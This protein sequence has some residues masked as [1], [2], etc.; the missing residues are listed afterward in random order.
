MERLVKKAMDKGDLLRLSMRGF[1]STISIVTT[2]IGSER[3][4]MLVSA[5]MSLALAPPLLA[6]A[7][8]RDASCHGPLRKRGSFC[9]NI[10][11]GSQEEIGRHF[12]VA[13]QRRRFADPAWAACKDERPSLK[14]L[15]FLQGAQS[16]IF[17]SVSDE[18]QYGTH[19]LF[20]G[21]VE[22][23]RLDGDLDPLV[24]CEGRFGRFEPDRNA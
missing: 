12:A 14:G 21:S 8:N 4:G 23:V 19:S 1:A 7:I 18:L 15:P 11:H 17:C 22:Q 6:V 24:Y 2:S 20:V 3:Y 5:I 13:E 16:S 10:L 9:V